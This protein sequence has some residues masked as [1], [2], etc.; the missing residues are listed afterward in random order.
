MQAILFWFGNAIYAMQA[1][2]AVWGVFCVIF[3]LRQTRRRSFRSAFLE[4]LGDLLRAR[5]FDD[6]EKLCGTPENWYRATPYLIR[7]AL[8]RRR[9]GIQKVRQIVASKFETDILSE[10][11]SRLTWVAT[12][13]KSEP[14]LGLLGTV[15]GMIGAFGEIT[16]GRPDPARLAENISLAL[17]T[18]A[19]GLLIAIPLL[20]ASNFVT[21]RMRKL[22]D[23]AG[24]ELQEALGDME[25]GMR[26]EVAMRA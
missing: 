24:E 7:E 3:L 9:H 8:Q 14:L 4:Q 17:I 5:R 12:A 22:E 6:A 18:T 11:E 25:A 15:A 26:G 20:F 19:V 21:V 16:T 10:L 2:V 13:I 23:A 1:L